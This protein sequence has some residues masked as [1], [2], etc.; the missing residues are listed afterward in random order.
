MTNTTNQTI[1]LQNLIAL[2]D[3]LEQLTLIRDTLIKLNKNK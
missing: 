3:S 1:E 2:Y